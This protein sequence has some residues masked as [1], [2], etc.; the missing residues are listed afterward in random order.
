MCQIRL[1]P[2]CG[3][4]ECLTDRTGIVAFPNFTIDGPAGS[5]E[6]QLEHATAGT[7]EETTTV[8]ACCACGCVYAC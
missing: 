8:H 5:Y 4:G 6:L 3:G 1:D 2:G 7:S